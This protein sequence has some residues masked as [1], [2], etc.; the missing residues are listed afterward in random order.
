MLALE[1]R[2]LEDLKGSDLHRVS[3]HE[4]DHSHRAPRV[5]QSQQASVVVETHIACAGQLQL[6]SNPVTTMLTQN[7]EGM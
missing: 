2:G 4:E 6:I 5:G 7:G 3:K 1:C